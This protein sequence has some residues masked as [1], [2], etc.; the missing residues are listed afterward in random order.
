MKH[1]IISILLLFLCIP[2]MPVGAAEQGNAPAFKPDPL[3]YPRDALEPYISSR[4]VDFH[5]GKHHQGYADNLN[6]LVTGTSFAGKTLETVVQESA[7]KEETKE[8]FNNAA[9]VWNHNFFWAGM[10]KNGGGRPAGI[11]LKKIEWSFGSYDAFA[12]KFKKAAIS[13][14]GSGY[15]WLVQDGEKLRVITTPN[16]YTPIVDMLHPILTCDVWE[17]A[18]YLDYQNRRGDF[19][20]AFLEHLVNWEVVTSRLR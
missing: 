8:V 5:Y 15:A 11:L 10:K 3:P 2:F 20:Q 14:F 12:E 9:Q 7:G 19:V 1:T 18:Y 6:K 13:Q 17:H 4:T 16:G